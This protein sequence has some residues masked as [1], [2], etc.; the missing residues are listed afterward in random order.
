MLLLISVSTAFDKSICTTPLGL[1]ENQCRWNSLDDNYADEDCLWARKMYPKNGVLWPRTQSGELTKSCD[2]TCS[3]ENSLGQINRRNCS[4]ECSSYYRVDDKDGFVVNKLYKGGTLVAPVYGSANVS[5]DIKLSKLDS[6]Y[7]SRGREYGQDYIGID[8]YIRDATT[9]NRP[10]FQDPTTEEWPVLTADTT[11]DEW[12]SKE[13]YKLTFDPNQTSPFVIEADG[14]VGVLHALTTLD[15]MIEGF[16]RAAFEEL[17]SD[18]ETSYR[19]RRHHHVGEDVMY[20]IPYASFQIEDWPKYPMRG[21]LLDT[22]RSFMTVSTI[23]KII[24]LMALSKLNTLQWHP[25]N[26]QSFS[27]LLGTTQK[28]EFEDDVTLICTREPWDDVQVSLNDDSSS[29]NMTDFVHGEFCHT[30][31]SAYNLGFC[32][33][34]YAPDAGY[35]RTDITEIINYSWLNGI[36]VLLGLESP[37]HAR[38]WGTGLIQACE[39]ADWDGSISAY[40]VVCPR[41][42]DKS[43]GPSSDMMLRCWGNKYQTSSM[44]RGQPCGL[45]NLTVE[46]ELDTDISNNNFK[47][48]QPYLLFKAITSS[49]ARPMEWVQ[50]ERKFTNTLHILNPAK[51]GCS[52]DVV[53]W[54]KSSYIRLAALFSEIHNGIPQLPQMVNKG[55]Y[56]HVGLEMSQSGCLD[57]VYFQG[58]SATLGFVKWAVA[59]LAIIKGF[60]WRPIVWLEPKLYKNLEELFVENKVVPQLWMGD[61]ADLVSAR[62]YLKSAQSYIWSASTSV[63]LDCGFGDPAMTGKESSCGRYKGFW[64]LYTSDPDLLQPLALAYQHH[65]LFSSSVGRL[66]AGPPRVRTRSDPTGRSRPSGVRC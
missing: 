51:Y 27:L 46:D 55:D 64:D 41:D 31:T 54:Y 24:D 16:N 1:L 7:I 44:C 34:L 21:L 17:Q 40:G 22:G 15:N 38:S 47:V 35:D 30:T 65:E 36:N 4:W 13:K 48:M 61:K 42:V 25:V 62:N 49:L 32:A 33:G 11:Y 19:V 66:L 53:C 26:D 28:C 9:L 50:V 14:L 6:K 45:L 63:Y 60:D 52:G 43:D 23:K 5:I 59:V 39:D 29:M 10:S 20:I 18:V 56:F 2:F 8:I 37:S 12:P 3:E 58:G 57:G